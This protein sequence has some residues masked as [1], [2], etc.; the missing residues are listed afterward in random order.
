MNRL[1]IFTAAVAVAFAMEGCKHVK[2]EAE[3]WSAS[4]TSLF[5]EN[6]V[7]GLE[8]RAGANVAL[9]VEAVRSALDPAAA[10]ALKTAAS[11]LA[12]AAR[13]CEACATSGASEAA[14]AAATCADGSCAAK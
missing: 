13:A 6:D 2:V 1:L 8:V 5:Q 3:N 14:S 9:K 12:L 10:E 7:K 11:A 4:Y